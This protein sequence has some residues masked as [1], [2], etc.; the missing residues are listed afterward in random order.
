MRYESE[1]DDQVASPAVGA[2]IADL[3]PGRARPPRPHQNQNRTEQGHDLTGGDDENRKDSEWPESA[4][5]RGEAIVGWRWGFGF[6][7]NQSR[8]HRTRLL[9]QGSLFDMAPRTVPSNVLPISR[10][11]RTTR[12]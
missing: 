8:L 10:C 7:S 12:W 4:Q 2:H 3:R 6:A 9:V 11:E 1:A 5:V